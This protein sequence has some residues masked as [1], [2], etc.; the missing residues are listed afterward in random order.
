MLILL[1]LTTVPWLCKTLALAETGY[2][3]TLFYP[4]HISIIF[5][6]KFVIKNTLRLEKRQLWRHMKK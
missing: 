6:N 2:T 4:C 3:E 5:Q 1:V